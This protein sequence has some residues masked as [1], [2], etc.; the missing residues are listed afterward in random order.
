[1]TQNSKVLRFILDEPPDYFL[2]SD[3]CAR[4]IRFLGFCTTAIPVAVYGVY[5]SDALKRIRDTKTRDEIKALFVA[6]LLTE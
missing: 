5:Y 4:V 6:F 1:M 3:V 2:Y